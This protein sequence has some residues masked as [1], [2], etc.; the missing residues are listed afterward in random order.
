MNAQK[1]SQNQRETFRNHETSRICHL[2]LWNKIVLCITDNRQRTAQPQR[3]APGNKI[4]INKS[5]P[6]CLPIYAC[7]QKNKL[8]SNT[9]Q[10]SNPDWAR[11]WFS[12]TQTKLH[13]TSHV[14]K[15][16]TVRGRNLPPELL[17]ITHHQI[18]ETIKTL[19]Y[20]S[21]WPLACFQTKSITEK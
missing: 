7:S 9:T 14:F 13:L 2:M 10:V 19:T 8:G 17:P 16:L 4:K 20:Q 21:S 3:C 5:L 15:S 11:L 18:K 12:P 6:L 1:S